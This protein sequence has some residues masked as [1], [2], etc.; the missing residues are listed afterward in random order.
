[1]AKL[2]DYDKKASLSSL[3]VDCQLLWHHLV[4]LWALVDVHLTSALELDAGKG[5]LH[6]NS[7]LGVH[8]PAVDSAILN[9]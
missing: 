7:S 9:L 8:S 2:L 5:D 3:R 6:Q 4:S 1:M